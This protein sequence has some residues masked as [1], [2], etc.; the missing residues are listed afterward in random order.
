MNSKYFYVEGEISP[1][2]WRQQLNALD[3]LPGG[4]RRN[5]SRSHRTSHTYRQSSLRARNNR[6]WYMNGGRGEFLFPLLFFLCTNWRTKIH[7]CEIGNSRLIL[8]DMSMNRK[9]FFSFGRSPAN[10]VT[11]NPFFSPSAALSLSLEI[12]ALSTK[13]ARDF[14][15][16]AA[17]REQSNH[18]LHD[19]V[20]VVIVVDPHL[21]GMTMIMQT[22]K[23]DRGIFRRTDGTRRA[24]ENRRL[25]DCG[26]ATT[27]A[28]ISET[29]RRFLNYL[30]KKR[31][32]Q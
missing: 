15:I 6:L 28:R 31:M 22:P 7:F 1:C 12:S 4:S 11:S 17:Q 30:T 29:R 3:A 21:D 25:R 26:P 18:C 23:I 19:R 32:M 27:K 8:V 13:A 14:Q 2:A 20:I 24:A 10:A 5:L 9:P 16:R